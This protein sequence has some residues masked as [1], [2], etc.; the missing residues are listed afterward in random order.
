[1]LQCASCLMAWGQKKSL[2]LS[3]ITRMKGA[4]QFVS[5]AGDADLLASAMSNAAEG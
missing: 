2:L 3:G 5:G 4:L 1:V